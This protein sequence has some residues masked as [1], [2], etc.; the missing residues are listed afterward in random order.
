MLVWLV[1]FLGC[2][3]GWLR[4]TRRG[5]TTPDRIQYALAHGIPAGLLALVVVVVSARM[6]W[7]P[8]E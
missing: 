6:G 2:G 7:L 4:A 5:G 3:F 8:Q 1:F